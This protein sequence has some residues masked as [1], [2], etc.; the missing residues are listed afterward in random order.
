MKFYLK[1]IKYYLNFLS[2]FTPKYGGKI[3]VRLFQKVRLREIKTREEP[4]YKNTQASILK[5]NNQDMLFYELGNPKGNLIFLVHGWD[6]NA[7]SLSMFAF[8]FAKNNY[9]VISLDL[10]A[11]AKSQGT[12]T[13]LFECKDALIQLIK[14]VNPQQKFSIIGHSFGAAVTSY[15]LAELDYKIKKIV[16]LSANNIMKVIFDDYQK[17]VG[18]N[19]KIYNQVSLWTK[20]NFNQSLEELILSDK[21]K[22]IKYDELLIIH[23]KFDK[24]LPFKSALEIKEAIPTTKII[25]FE[26]IGHYRMLWNKEVL[27]ETI[28]FIIQ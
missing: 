17:L 16:L 27:K 18:F 1:L 26:K 5:V 11:H 4:F 25:A 15:A 3:A 12:H 23:D 28:K 2:V 8:E 10:P 22:I 9:R 19:D 20:Q 7:G 14:H 21:I 6:S 13:N 24:V